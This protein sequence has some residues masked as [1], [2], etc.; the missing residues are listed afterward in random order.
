MRTGSCLSQG[1][2]KR[3][4]HNHTNFSQTAEATPE[5]HFKE[6]E[7]EQL[8]FIFFRADSNY[9][10]YTVTVIVLLALSDR[11]YSSEG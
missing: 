9:C 4:Q 3:Q 2:V 11:S 7:S 8:L 10:S 1:K 6:R 5:A